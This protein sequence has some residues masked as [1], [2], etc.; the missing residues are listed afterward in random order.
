MVRLTLS[1]GV[2]VLIIHK[3]VLVGAVSSESDG[4][5]TQTGETTLEPIPAREGALVSPSLTAEGD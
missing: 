5:C 2:M 3:E 1:L 4:S